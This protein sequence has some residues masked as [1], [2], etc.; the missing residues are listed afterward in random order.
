MR[1]QVD[2][3][4]HPVGGVGDAVLDDLDADVEP[5]V[6]VDDV[7]TGEALDGVA[8][9][10]AEDD[11]RGLRGVEHD[12]LGIAVR[13]EDRAALGVHHRDADAVRHQL[14]KAVDE[15]DVLLQQV[16]GE[17]VERGV[18]TRDGG[19]TGRLRSRV[20]GSDTTREDVVVLPARQAFDE[21]EAVTQD[22]RLLVVEERDAEVGVRRHGVTLVDRPV[23]AGHAVVALDALG[24][25]HDVV[26]GLAVVVGVAGCRR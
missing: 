11:V 24:L 14:V 4:G 15:R 22:E 1:L 21:V 12:Q 6:A 5:L 19:R 25:E 9:A 3:S 10:T 7:V 8:A 26:A 20:S 17:G 18:R 2:L 13:I 23:E 16:V